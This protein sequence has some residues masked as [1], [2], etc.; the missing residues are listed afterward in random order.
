MVRAA[1]ALV[2]VIALLCLSHSL[3]PW[4]AAQSSAHVYCDGDG[5]C[6]TCSDGSNGTACQPAAFTAT[7]WA[8]NH[9]G[10]GWNTTCV[11]PIGQSHNT[12]AERVRLR[13]QRALT[14]GPRVH[15]ACVR[16]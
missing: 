3:L 7:E 6:L 4:A 8:M 10:A 1:D 12:A 9:T 2:A 5:A 15:D 11:A 14:V 16:V 13:L